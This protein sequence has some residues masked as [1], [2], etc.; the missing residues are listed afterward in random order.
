MLSN[1]NTKLKAINISGKDHKTF[2]EIIDIIGIKLNK[3]IFKLFLPKAPFIFILK[4]IE[5]NFNLYLPI[6][7]EQIQRL[8][9]NKNFSNDIAKKLLLYNPISI[10]EGLN[11]EIINYKK[12]K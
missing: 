11:A 3:K 8:N 2:N 1:E 5:K 10:D 9:E 12:K 7:S 4:F 6:K